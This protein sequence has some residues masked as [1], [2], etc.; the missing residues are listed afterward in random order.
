MPSFQRFGIKSNVGFGE[1]GFSLGQSACCTSHRGTDE[2]EE[3]ESVES[4]R[5][6]CELD[7]SVELLEL[8]LMFL[9]SFDWPLKLYP[10]FGQLYAHE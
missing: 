1:H 10:T 2:R 6:H 7:V 5:F 9:L 3:D 4:E 8:G